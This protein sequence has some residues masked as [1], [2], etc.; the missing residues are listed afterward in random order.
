MSSLTKSWIWMEKYAS[1]VSANYMNIS[2]RLYMKASS[3]LDE[4]IL[5]G[6][7]NFWKGQKMKSI[8]KRKQQNK[9]PV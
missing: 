9:N 1:C 5:K 6:E 3:N 4:L 2:F 8:R 7:E